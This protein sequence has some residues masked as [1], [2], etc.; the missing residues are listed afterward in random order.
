MSESKAEEYLVFF[1]EK[2]KKNYYYNKEKNIS[3]WTLPEG[4]KV[5]Q[6]DQPQ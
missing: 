2:Y 1:D 3:V 5:V 4:A 6:S